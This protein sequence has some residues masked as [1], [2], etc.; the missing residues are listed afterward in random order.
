MTPRRKDAYSCESNGI[1]SLPVVA[2][3]L[4]PMEKVPAGHVVVTARLLKKLC[5][6][7]Q[8]E[9]CFFRVDCSLQP[10][11]LEHSGWL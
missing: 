8:R 10:L 6:G 2:E 9:M 3:H 4:T 11:S 1:L 5:W 7:M